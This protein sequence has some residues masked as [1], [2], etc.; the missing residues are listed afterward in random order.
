MPQASDRTPNRALSLTPAL[1]EEL[2]LLPDDIV[3]VLSRGSRTVQLEIERKGGPSSEVP[4]L[5]A[6]RPLVLHAD[7]RAFPLADVLQLVHTPGKSGLLHFEHAGTEKRVYLHR[8][9]VVF[10]RSNQRVD[11][12]ELSVAGRAV[13]CELALVRLRVPMAETSAPTIIMPL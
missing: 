13:S 9:E 7:V 3:R 4:A 11:R 10:A 5:P 12:L 2:E 8:G 1:R 6:G